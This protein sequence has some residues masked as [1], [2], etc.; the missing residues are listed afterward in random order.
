MKPYQRLGLYGRHDK[1]KLE[2]NYIPPSSSKTDLLQDT[3]LLFAVRKALDEDP[4]RK[5]AAPSASNHAGSDIARPSFECETLSVL[6]EQ[7]KQTDDL[8]DSQGLTDHLFERQEH[9]EN[10][11]TARAE[12]PV[13]R[14]E[15][16][17]PTD[18]LDTEARITTHDDLGKAGEQCGEKEKIPTKSG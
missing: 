4:P 15:W 8:T 17:Q 12:P 7:Q 18:K 14:T 1:I 6:I 3:K 13:N 16:R 2:E 10:H 11:L 5:P 9:S